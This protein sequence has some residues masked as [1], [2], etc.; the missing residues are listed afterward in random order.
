M[1]SRSALAPHHAAI[2]A[3]ILR[4]LSHSSPDDLRRFL[5]EISIQQ[6]VLENI[7]DLWPDLPHAYDAEREELADERKEV[8][9]LYDAALDDRER[10]RRRWERL[11]N[12]HRWGRHEVEELKKCRDYMARNAVKMVG[13][14]V[15]YTEFSSQIQGLVPFEDDLRVK[16]EKLYVDE[17]LSTTSKLRRMRNILNLYSESRGPRAERYSYRRRS[18]SP[19]EEEDYWTPKPDIVEPSRDGTYVSISYQ[20]H[21]SRSDRHENKRHRRD[22]EEQ[23]R[24]VPD[25]S[26]EV[27]DIDDAPQ[28]NVYLA[29]SSRHAFRSS[30]HDTSFLWRSTRAAKENE[31][32]NHPHSNRRFSLSYTHLP[33]ADDKRRTSSSS[34]PYRSSRY[35]DD[36][37]S[38]RPRSSSRFLEVPQ[39]KP[40]KQYT[41]W[42]VYEIV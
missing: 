8:Y 32:H 1:A 41:P 40:V 42:E 16:L 31:Y 26:Y 35:G 27:E 9:I 18:L 19:D 23:S 17:H 5:E 10:I 24:Y 28:Q 6:D 33:P 7:Y 15:E 21:R 4:L 14:C 39:A 38:R 13:L 11:L 22:R 2:K 3:Q 36:E 20:K 12:K 34:K 25:V 37:E 29:D 30:S